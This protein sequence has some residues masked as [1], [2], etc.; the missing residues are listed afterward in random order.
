MQTERYQTVLLNNVNIIILAGFVFI[1]LAK[2]LNRILISTETIPFFT[3][4]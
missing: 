3:D 4:S 2:V 1:L